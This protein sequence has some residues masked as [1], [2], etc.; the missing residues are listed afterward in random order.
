[1]SGFKEWVI[2]LAITLVLIFTFGK[3]EAQGLGQP[4]N[5]VD[6]SL[7]KT[8]VVTPTRT[9]TLKQS[10]TTVIQDRGI[11]DH[12]GKRPG[13]DVIRD[14]GPSYRN[15]E[16]AQSGCYCSNTRKFNPHV[17]PR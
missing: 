6:E 17:S 13:S 2:Y 4:R 3:A 9:Y 10:G 15:D 1:M 8:I 12:Q 7:N 5:W 16:A 14:Y 11:R